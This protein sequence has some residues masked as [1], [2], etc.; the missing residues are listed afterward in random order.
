MSDSWV[1]NMFLNAKEKYDKN[2][3]VIEIQP[4]QSELAEHVANRY[5]KSG[6]VFKGRKF[7]LTK[8]M[9]RRMKELLLDG[10]TVIKAAIID[11]E[12]VLEDIKLEDFKSPHNIKDKENE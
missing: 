10:Q 9:N 6:V 8:E 5:I 7:G 1:E 3:T 12:L 11:D 4:W 2:Y